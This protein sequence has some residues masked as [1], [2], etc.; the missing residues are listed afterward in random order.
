M[1]ERRKRGFNPDAIKKLQRETA[2][3]SKGRNFLAELATPAAFSKLRSESTYAG[4]REKLKKTGG[5]AA[6]SRKDMNPRF[7]GQ[8][9]GGRYTTKAYADFMRKMREGHKKYGITVK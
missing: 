8:G 3:P 6:T 1:I 5:S 4:S 7:K 9:A 2:R